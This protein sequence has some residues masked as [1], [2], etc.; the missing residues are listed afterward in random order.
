M[1]DIKQLL[2]IMEA[3]EYQLIKLCDVLNYE[4]PTKYI[5][6]S[7][8][9]NDSYDTPVLTAGQSFILGYTDEREGV[10][11]AS[12]EN[13][14]IIF[15]DFTTGFHWVNFDFKVKSSAMK[16]LR[17]INSE[18]SFRYIFH[19]MSNIDFVPGTH[20]RHWISI[21]SQF[22]IPLPSYEVQCKIADVLDL[23][24]DLN[25][26]LSYE[27]LLRKKQYSFYS[28]ILLKSADADTEWVCIRDLIISLKTGMNPRKNFVLNEEGSIY[29]YVTG[30][31]IYDN[32]V[33]PSDK[34]DKITRT[35]VKLINKRACLENDDL[36]FASTGTG[37]VGRMAIVK[38]YNDD[39][40]VS[41]T[42]FIL[43]PKKEIVSSLYL[44]YA[45]YSET[46]RAQFEPKIS[47]GSV[48]HLKV[49]DLLN[50]K[51]P[52]PSLVEQSVL[53]E[54]LKKFDLLCNSSN[55]G[56]QK[57]IDFRQ[58]QYEYVRQLLISVRR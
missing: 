36:L 40:A 8:E 25:K 23:F 49:E 33:K 47:K 15:D 48:P 50:V 26:K 39:W 51:I 35:I 37:T 9:Y 6:S 56:I 34:T 45:L 58:L 52:L 16:M 18:V 19:A 55:L 11:N 38:D 10:F 30:K 14:V 22:E 44:M 3:G 27:H 31:D 1:S 12:D 28:G 54:K 17:P 21:Y 5:V 4:Q 53:V 7:T 46:A 43:K 2:K 29:H 57:E 42:L 41:E 24:S 13:P 20:S 32:E